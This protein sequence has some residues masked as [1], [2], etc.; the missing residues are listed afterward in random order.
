[1]GVQ[2]VAQ[3]GMPLSVSEQAK[4]DLGNSPFLA[5]LGFALFTFQVEHT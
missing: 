3:T 5:Y 1:M 4:R 2:A